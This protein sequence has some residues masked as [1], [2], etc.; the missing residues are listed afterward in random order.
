MECSLQSGFV[1]GMLVLVANRSPPGT[2]WPAA[3]VMPCGQ[4]LRLRH[5]G[6]HDDASRDFWCDV[7]S[8]DVRPI[9]SCRDRPQDVCPPDGLFHIRVKTIGRAFG[10]LC[11]L[12]SVCCL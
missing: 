1:K 6:C 5:V 8:A 10:T 11:R 3:I 4:L 7:T 12:S 9:S 2:Y